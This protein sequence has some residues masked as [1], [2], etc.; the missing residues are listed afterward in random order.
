MTLDL[1]FMKDNFNVMKIILVLVKALGDI[2]NSMMLIKVLILVG[3]NK[4]FQEGGAS[5]YLKMKQI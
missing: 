1:A 2:F 4:A 5:L 3:G